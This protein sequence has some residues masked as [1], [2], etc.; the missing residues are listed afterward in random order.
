MKWF[1]M[2]RLMS[3]FLV[4]F[5]A[6]NVMAQ[7]PAAWDAKFVKMDVP[8]SVEADAV[9]AVKI[10]MKNTGS[11]KWMGGLGITPSSLRSIP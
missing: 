1:A 11:E 5:A 10:T 4:L 8:D 2:K 6:A 9:F 3:L 7:P